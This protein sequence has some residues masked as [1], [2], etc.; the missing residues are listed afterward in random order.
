[1]EELTWKE[2]LE[3]V[4]VSEID[5]KLRVTC[6][7]IQDKEIEEIPNYFLVAPNIFLTVP[8]SK[9]RNEEYF[10]CLERD[11]PEVYFAGLWRVTKINEEDYNSMRLKVWD[12]PNAEPEKVLEEFAKT[13]KFLKE[14][15]SVNNEV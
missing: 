9:E 6:D 7:L 13:F 15:A 2:I 14:E 5:T 12:L 1:M 10:L 8:V 3:K 4:E 11:R